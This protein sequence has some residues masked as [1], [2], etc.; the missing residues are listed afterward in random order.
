MPNN[1]RDQLKT[2]WRNFALRAQNVQRPE[3]TPAIIQMTVLVNRDGNPFLWTEPKVILLE[4][5]VDFDIAALNK[6]LSPEQMLALL[7][8]ISQ[9]G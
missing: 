8:V 5:R 6:A 2:A 9:T 7:D 4:P 3:D 1:D